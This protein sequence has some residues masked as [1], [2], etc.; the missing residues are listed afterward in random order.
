M[1]KAVISIILVAALV[2]A[3]LL[4]GCWLFGVV[5]GS[6][7]LVT[8]EMDFSDFT[9]VEVGHA[10]E[11]EI[12]Q[13]GSYSVSIT[14]DDNL[15]E[16]IQVSKSGETLKMGL[17]S[18][19]GYQSVTLRAKI[20]MPELHGL[21]LS[22][23]TRGTA[24][25]FSSSHDFVLE[26]SGASSLDMVDMSAGDIKFD[27]SGASVVTGSISAVDA[28]F[29]LS[30]ASRVE[31][32]GS[33]NNMLITSSGASHLELADFPVRKVDINLSGASEASVNLCVKLDVDLSGGS[34]LRYIGEPI[35]GD[36]N[37]SGGSVIE[38]IELPSRPGG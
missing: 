23:A 18:P 21:D 30:G 35:L 31:L 5:T 19:Y 7:N 32:E 4:S 2:T 6:G 16:Y 36:L 37:I 22:G 38:K 9:R 8:E 20:T 25:G 1:R 10:F 34:N 28:Q 12:T 24:Q 3:V 17:K 29:D 15:F 27:L 13:S 26:L 33:A 14:A 11:V